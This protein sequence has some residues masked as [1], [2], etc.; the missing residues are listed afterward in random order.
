MGNYIVQ[1]DIEQQISAA[2]VIQLTDDSGGETVDLANLN[3]VIDDAEGIANGYLEDRYTVP[4]SP[5]P[6]G[7]KTAVV[8]IAVYRLHLR[9]PGSVTDDVSRQFKMAMDFLRDVAKGVASLGTTTP[10]PDTTSHS[11]DFQADDRK[12][13]D[14]S[15]EGF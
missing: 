5:V 10:A 7:L 11:V 15:M 12:F 1:A 13:T 3:A 2:V 4:L 6:P 14:E 9:R 8:D